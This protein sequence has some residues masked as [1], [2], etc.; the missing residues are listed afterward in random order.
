GLY[1]LRGAARLGGAALGTVATGVGAFA[2]GVGLGMKLDAFYTGNEQVEARRQSYASAI[3]TRSNTDAPLLERKLAAMRFMSDEHR[4]S[5]SGG[6]SGVGHYFAWQ[7]DK[8]L[9]F[10]A[11]RLEELQ[12]RADVNAAQPGGR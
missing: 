5:G 2:T 8:A 9:G 12:T 6:L 3:L 4:L 10:D 11:Q 1:A 7:K